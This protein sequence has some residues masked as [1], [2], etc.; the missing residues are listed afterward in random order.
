MVNREIQGE[1]LPPCMIYIDKDGRWFHREAEMVHHEII[2][3][4]YRHMEMDAD[5]RII[6][7]WRGERCYVEVEDTPF[8][9]K[10]VSKIEPDQGTSE[11]FELYLSD[12]E[13]E[14]LS[15]ESLRLGEKGVLY[16]SV[17]EGTFPARFSRPAYYQLAEHIREEKGKFY[18]PFKGEKYFI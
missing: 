6:I 2:G 11:S 17:R 7:N 5:G 1:D 13:R 12:G 8:I 15:P 10:R 14:E 9:V 4:F 18:L 16:C 3:H